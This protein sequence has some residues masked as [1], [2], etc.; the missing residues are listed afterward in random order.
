MDRMELSFLIRM[1]YL[2][3]HPINSLLLVFLI[4]RTIMQ[5][6]HTNSS[7]SMDLDTLVGLYWEPNY[8]LKA[9]SLQYTTISKIPSI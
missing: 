3:G 6:K 1:I 4:I 8:N 7:N 2:K 9:D 5:I